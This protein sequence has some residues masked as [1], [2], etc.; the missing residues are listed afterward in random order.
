VALQ[1]TPRGLATGVLPHGD[2]SFTILFDFIEHQLVIDTS[3]GVRR[4]VPLVPRSVAEFY[5]VVMGTLDEM[6][7]PV[8]IWSTPVEIPSPIP[9]ERDAVH[10]S[11]TRN[12][13]TASGVCCSRCTACSPCRDAG[14]SG[15]AALSTSSGGV[16][17][18]PS[19]VSRAGARRRARVLPSCVTRIHMK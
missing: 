1:L 3:D 12:M 14:S 5:G 18:W 6:G 8:R 4:S 15:N 11:Y 7:L 13:R 19:P 9:F 2:R 10:H 16:S 17:I